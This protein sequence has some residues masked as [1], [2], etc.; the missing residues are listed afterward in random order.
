[1]KTQ[2]FV[3]Q[4]TNARLVAN[5]VFFIQHLENNIKHNMIQ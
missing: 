3:D 5:V 4:D 2:L 1:M